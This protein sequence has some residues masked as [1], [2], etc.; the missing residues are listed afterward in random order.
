M[1]LNGI[2]KI[3]LFCTC[4]MDCLFGVEKEIDR[5]Y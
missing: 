5:L 4:Q 2:Y 1:E 3:F